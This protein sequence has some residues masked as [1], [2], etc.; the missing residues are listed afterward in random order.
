MSLLH[1]LIKEMASA[2]STGAGSIA[3]YPGSLL[4]GGLVDAKKRKKKNTKMLRRVINI[5]EGL[6][7]A[8]DTNNF[9][10][11]D[12]ISKIQ[13]AAKRN[14]K[15]RDTVAFGLEDEDGNMI[16]VYV[17]DADAEQFEKQLAAMLAGEDSDND[18]SNTSLE[19]AEVLFKLKDKFDIAD[20]EWPNIEGDVEEEQEVDDGMEA[21]TGANDGGEM[22]GEGDLSDVS[23][24][25]EGGIDDGGM[26]DGSDDAAKSAL[27]QVIDMMKADA[28]ARRAEADAK[29]AEARA[30]EAE[31]GAR[32]A[33]FN[34]R[35][36]EQLYDMK[37]A[38]KEAKDQDKEAKQM[39]KLARYQHDQAQGAE[40][41]L[42]MENT[43]NVGDAVPYKTNQEDDDLDNTD[44]SLEELSALIIRNLGHN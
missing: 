10:S 17:A 18:D 19:I 43:T 21:P 3:A 22:G 12:V 32:L 31:A 42:S 34:I 26:G 29:Q 7:I 1:A 2:G 39:A 20:V 37:A 13:S 8:K 28:E 41:K 30:K 35:K 44:I 36:D 9:D 14:S 27:N 38:E 16:K 33:S 4:G 6:G 11:S 5:G 40:V 25:E 15:D 23:A 24:S